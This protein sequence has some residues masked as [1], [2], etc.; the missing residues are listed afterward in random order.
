MEEPKID[1]MSHKM[2]P[3]ILIGLLAAAF[4]WSADAEE[5]K[6]ERLK[7]TPTLDGKIDADPAW[8]GVTAERGFTTLREGEPVPRKTDFRMGYRE[9]SL[10]VAVWCEEPQ[11]DE[12]KGEPDDT[13][14]L[15]TDDC[16]EL[17]LKPAQTGTYYQF[18]VN[19]FGA[20]RMSRHPGNN[21]E[22]STAE[23]AVYRGEQHWSLELKIPFTD[24]R[25]VPSAGDSWTGNVARDR[26]P[27][28]SFRA[29]WAPVS[30]MHDPANF[31]MFTFEGS[32]AIE[33]RR[34][35]EIKKRIAGKYID[36]LDGAVQTG[37]ERM[38]RWCPD[39]YKTDVKS[40]LKRWRQLKEQYGQMEDISVDESDRLLRRVRSFRDFQKGED[41]MEK[42][43]E[44]ADAD[45][46]RLLWPE[47][48][49]EKIKQKI[50]K[51]P[52]LK[53]LYKEIKRQAT[54][55]LEI[56]P[57]E[58]KM[59]GRRLLGVS[60]RCFKRVLYLSLVYRLTGNE[61]YCKRAQE[62]MLAVSGFKDWNPSHF[63]DV[64]EMTAALGIGYDWL[65]HDLDP[66]A[67]KQIRNA[68][69]EKGLR[70]SMPGA[71]W[72]QA[73]NNWGQVCHGGLALGALAV[74]RQ[75]PALAASILARSVRKIKYPMEQ[76]GPRGT[77]PEGPG[78]WG[79]GTTYN[80]LCIDALQ[81][82]LGNDF[83][84]SEHEGLMSSP[85]YYM[86]CIG[87]TGRQFNYSDCGPNASLQPAMFWF[88]SELEEPELLFLERRNLQSFAQ[89]KHDAA[90]SG[91]YRKVFTLLWAKNLA[92][93]SPP[94]RL[95]WKGQGKTPIGIHRSEWG[96]DGVYVGLKGGSPETNHAH[97]DIGSFV[98]EADGVRW[99]VDLGSQNY[100][101]LEKRG[102]SLF[103]M[104][105]DSERWQV[106]RLNNDSHNTLTVNGEHQRVSG[107][108]PL[109][110]FSDKDPAYSAIDMSS[111]YE[112]QLARALRTV[113]LLQK[114]SAVAIRDVLKAP[115][116]TVTVRW[117][118][119]TRADVKIQ[120]HGGQAILSQD[121][122]KLTLTVK[123]PGNVRLET[124][125]T[126]PP[127]SDYDAANPGTCMVGFK[128]RLEPS[129]ES[130]LLVL[131]TPGTEGAAEEAIEE[132][133]DISSP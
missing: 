130:R 18:L 119:V 97:M 43:L 52:L 96:E 88:A 113:A 107:H 121:H 125:R 73:K 36:Q 126:N 70:A 53:Q 124:Y 29:V 77:Y 133:P 6:L 20:L 19:A 15:W 100:H 11:M 44:K 7:E 90:E 47:N 8:K 27:A 114:R 3:V 109:I 42:I 50:E 12:L 61:E 30:G 46:P 54:E 62:E 9:T 45:R 28:P 91:G 22:P 63:L 118:M 40:R 72:V 69:V 99:A 106:F 25:H 84:L 13:S 16:I 34:L 86:H 132:M 108:A 2:L 131:L 14:R 26:Q 123:K 51:H 122:K 105:Q 24:V 21:E 68:I 17:F 56:S 82:A 95:D 38:Q 85:R 111:V 75:D 67:R 32:P 35:A 115:D 39:S 104:A 5:Y 48:G 92:D 64:A 103:N 10:Y 59:V 37:A 116:K 33:P 66:Q 60:R 80:V 110:A 93:V 74:H 71:W 65:Y 41:V 55:M 112:E 120:D 102:F 98:M 129:E 128:V 31:G 4:T 89:K 117:G 83:G 1:N 94:D 58:H 49:S 78:Y 101:S 87:P 79:Y 127:P 76:Y 57:V 23:S 81:T